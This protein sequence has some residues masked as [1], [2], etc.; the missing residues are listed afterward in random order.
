V[1]LVPPFAPDSADLLLLRRAQ[2]LR[3]VRFDLVQVEVDQLL[4]AQAG[5]E[6]GVHDRAVA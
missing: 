1:R 4:A 5:T 2:R 3:R 6:Q